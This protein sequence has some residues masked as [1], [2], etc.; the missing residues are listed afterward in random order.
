MISDILLHA[1][2]ATPL[3]PTLVTVWNKNEHTLDFLTYLAMTVCAHAVHKVLAEI[4]EIIGE[5]TNR[6]KRK[7]Q[8]HNILRAGLVMIIYVQLHLDLAPRK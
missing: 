5:H 7:T 4:V 1:V 6:I 8:S 2:M 3:T